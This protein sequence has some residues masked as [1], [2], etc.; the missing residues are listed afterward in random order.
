V[1]ADERTPFAHLQCETC[2]GPGGD[3]TKRLH[4]GQPRPPIPF[5][6]SKSPASVAE[7]NAVCTNCHKGDQ[8][9]QWHGSTH[10]RED[11]ACVS[12]H[13]IHAEKDPVLVKSEQPK[14]CLTCHK[15]VRT[16][17]FKASA[18]PVR[19]G[20]MACTDCHAP[21]GSTGPE[22]LT[23]ATVNQTCYTC[24]ADKR[25]PFLWEHEPASEDC[26]LCHSPHGSNHPAMLT[27]QA[28]LLCQSC[29]SPAGHPSIAQGPS[30]LPG[31]GMP[32]G[33][34]LGGSCLNCHS[35]VH[36]S[37]SPS[38]ATLQR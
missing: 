33:F 18:H 22:L 6:G 1:K 38:G 37:N 24:H 35:Q 19:Q 32:S 36:G 30:G 20:D 25:G 4:P 29:H 10:Q 9:M 26:T 15:D 13:T 28:P 31:Q 14:V 11:I 34:L 8:L 2:H 12:C 7:E 23:K 5:F 16:D 3:H 17:M 27:R 21:H